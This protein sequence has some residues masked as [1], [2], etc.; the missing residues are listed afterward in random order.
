MKEI[1]IVLQHYVEYRYD[2]PPISIL[3]WKAFFENIED[4]E[5]YIKSRSLPSNYEIIDWVDYYES[6]AKEKFGW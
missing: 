1:Y 6:G 2:E 5:A 3:V 4:A